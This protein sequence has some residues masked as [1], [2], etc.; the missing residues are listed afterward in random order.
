MIQRKIVGSGMTLGFAL[1]AAVVIGSSVLIHHNIQL[2]ADNEDEVVHTYE[3]IT[4][5]GEIRTAL[6]VAESSQRGYLITTDQNYLSPYQNSLPEITR[7]LRTLEVLTQDN[8]TQVRNL[9]DLTGSVTARLD[10]LA[11]GV[12]I[13]Q[14]NGRDA[15]RDFILKGVGYTQMQ[16]VRDDLTKMMNVEKLLLDE[17]NAESEASHVATK[18]TALVAAVVGLSMVLLAWYLSFRE[19]VRREMMASQLEARVRERTSELDAANTALQ[20]SNRELEQFASVASHDL[21]EPLRK[22]EA[23][24]DRLKMDRETLGEQ[25]RDYLDRILNS[26][27]RM[28]KLISDLLTFS[29]V[30]SRAQPFKKLDL[31]QVAR[32]VVGDLEGRIQQVEGQVEL[33]DL[34]Q[35]DADPTQV[36]QLL[37]N[38]IANGLKFHRPDVKPVVHVNAKRIDLAGQPPRVELT[39][40]DNGIGFEEQYLDRIFE[41]FQRLHGRNEF[42]GTGIGLAICRKIVERHGGTITA[43]S[44]PGEG[45]TF[46]VTLPME[47]TG[48]EESW[49][50]ANP[51][52]S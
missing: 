39:V 5:L 44:K 29:R 46:I 35:I 17:R 40:A 24:G 9:K 10:S 48:K 15:G 3:V 19:V 26:A 42:E 11:E 2:I 8:V 47:Q 7:L 30:A 32:E 52:S 31:G 49:G 43:R 16:K 14:N 45:A 50:T 6:N 37:Q 34:P 4:T 36:R 23:F 33:G 21:Q 22:I 1:A 12:G 51:S 25:S 20:Q 27:S 28:R 18:R 13:A 38:L 41:V